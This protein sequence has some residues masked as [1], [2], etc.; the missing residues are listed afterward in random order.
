[1]EVLPD[2]LDRPIVAR[3]VKKLM[4]DGSFC[5]ALAL[6]LIWGYAG[7]GYGPQRVKKILT[8][9]GNGPSDVAHRLD[10]SW[11]IATGQNAG[12]GIVEAYR[13]LNNRAAGHIAYLGPSFFTKWL[14]FATADSDSA[15]PGAAPILDEVVRRWLNANT[16][17]DLHASCTTCYGRYI[18]LLTSWASGPWTPT[19]IEEAIFTLPR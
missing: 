13:Y 12:Q 19:R 3:Q 4:A 7:T 18:D 5:E 16:N 2:E 14:H 10:Q 9:T 6:V 15:A 17:A 1:M 8:R 11:Q